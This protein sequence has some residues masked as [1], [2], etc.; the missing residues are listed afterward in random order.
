MTANAGAA[1]SSAVRAFDRDD[2][3]C[4]LAVTLV[5][6]LLDYADA[7]F[8]AL[9][10]ERMHA[11][12]VGVRGKPAVDALLDVGWLDLFLVAR[13]QQPRYAFAKFRMFMNRL[14]PGLIG[15]K[16]PPPTQHV[17]RRIADGQKTWLGIDRHPADDLGRPI[18]RLAQIGVVS[19]EISRRV[20]LKIEQGPLVGVGC[21]GSKRCGNAIERIA[22][23][24]AEQHNG[25]LNSRRKG[26]LLRAFAISASHSAGARCLINLAMPSV[27]LAS[28]SA[29][30][31]LSRATS[32]AAAIR[33][34]LNARLPSGWIGTA[35]QFGAQAETTCAMRIMSA[36]PLPLVLV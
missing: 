34:S 27:A 19:V 28:A 6:D 23:V 36:L 25:S 4:N 5:F 26:L 9:G 16:R 10:V 7:I 3:L 2:P 15:L 1:R 35:R 32:F 12:L 29:S 8:P 18:D 24:F 33:P 13:R 11:R 22:V 30:W 21:I 17:V 20:E 14:R 31:A